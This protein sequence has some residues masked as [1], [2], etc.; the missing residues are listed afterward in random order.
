[1]N[2]VKPIWEDK[3]NS[4]NIQI[5]KIFALSHLLGASTLSALTLRN[6]GTFSFQQDGLIE[7]QSTRT[8]IVVLIFYKIS[9][10]TWSAEI[11]L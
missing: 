3:K 9:S 10:P 2:S 8:L 11:L 4:L 5:L 7:I 1:M 6:I